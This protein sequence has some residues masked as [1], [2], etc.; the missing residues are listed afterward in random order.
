[1]FSFDV[2]SSAEG[3][4]YII[5]RRMEDYMRGTQ[6]ASRTK[7]TPLIA[8]LSFSPSSSALA[9]SLSISITI[10]VLCANEEMKHRLSSYVSRVK[11]R[12]A[13]F[14]QSYIFPLW[15]LKTNKQKKKA[16]P[17]ACSQVWSRWN[18]VTLRSTQTN[19]TDV[20]S[21][22]EKKLKAHLREKI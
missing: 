16:A 10:T 3:R 17:P 13:V 5:V 11:D 21:D 8:S 15:W 7:Q 18:M 22:G 20:S 14:T 6:L 1:M 2:V 9:F 19:P 12:T 4:R